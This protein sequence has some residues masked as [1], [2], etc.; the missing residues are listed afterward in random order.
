M[1]HD[2]DIVIMRSEWK[3]RWNDWKFEGRGIFTTLTPLKTFCA[4]RL[5]A[6]HETINANLWLDEGYRKFIDAAHGFRQ[7]ID[8]KVQCP[9]CNQVLMAPEDAAG[10]KVRCRACRTT[11]FLA[12]PGPSF[13]PVELSSDE[14][15][16]PETADSGFALADDAPQK[17]HRCNFCKA[18]V[19]PEHTI[20][21]ECG[22]NRRTGRMSENVLQNNNDI[23]EEEGLPFHLLTIQFISELMP[24]LFRPG[25]LIVTFLL[26]VAGFFVMGL[27]IF[28][29][30]LG[31]VGSAMGIAGA[32]LVVYGQA[33]GVLLY[34]EWALLS[35]CLAEFDG[36]RWLLF[37]FLL[38]SPFAA[39]F[40][41]ARLLL[42]M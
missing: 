13:P 40:F 8:V 36:R 16:P 35:E 39:L 30:S 34:G 6:I 32:G 19:S 21:P 11:F 37:F 10:R 27:G 42:P 1:R 38:F 18:P 24:G 33:L 41:L 31:A 4:V 9:K 22:Y 26:T 15:P 7:H 25:L 2:L 17:I 12:A 29:F 5:S 20:C 23:Q 28:I 14:P 3:Y